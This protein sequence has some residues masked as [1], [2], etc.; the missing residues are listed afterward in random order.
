MTAK[1][2][3]PPALVNLGTIRYAQGKLE[4]AA[5]LYM[6]AYNVNPDLPAALLGLA[7]VNHDQENY[8]AVRTYYGRL[9]QLD[10]RL[11][12]KYSYLGLRGEE[13]TRAENASETRREFVWAQ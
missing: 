1:S 3:Y 8:G 2:E 11:A 4:E 13:G 10:E 5:A 12:E 9:G 7:R 6:R